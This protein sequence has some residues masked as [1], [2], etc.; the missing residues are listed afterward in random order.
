MP[1][2]LGILLVAFGAFLAAV[3][4]V[5]L[6]V[7]SFLAANGLLALISHRVHLDTS[8]SSVMLL[9]G[10]AV[11]VDYCMFYLR[12]VARGARAGAR[13]RTRRS[14]SRRRP[15][16]ARCLVSGLTVVV[17]MSG[18]FLSGML[19][20]DGFAIAA[21]LV[22]L[23]AVVG[24]VTVLPALLS[25][26][27]DRVDFGRVPGLARMRRPQRRQQGVGCDPRPRPA[28]VQGCPSGRPWRSCS[29][30]RRRVLGIT[31]RLSLDKLLPSSASIMQSLPAD[32][33]MPSRRT[34]PGRPRHQGAGRHKRRHNRRRGRL[35]SRAIATQPRAPADPGDRARVV[36]RDRDLR[37]PGRQRHRRDVRRAL[38]AL[39]QD[40][41]PAPSGSSRARG[42]RDR[43]L[44]F[45]QDFNA[46]L[47]R[48]IVPVILFVLVIAFV[49]MLVAFRSVTIA[50]VSVLL[51]VLS[52]SGR[53]RCDGGC[54]PARLGCE[55]RGRD[56]RR[57]RSSRGSRC[58]PS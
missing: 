38:D 16:D 55:P 46:Q 33:V 6:A 54:L 3:L 57:S 22:V 20:F 30:S 14:A 12:R 15:Q 10:L 24:S 41:V 42:V 32:H 27:G 47:Q 17:A 39:R 11:G 19:L 52:M 51:N 25:V 21:I 44:A 48:S 49:L 31:E 56:R 18:M 2:A 9:V 26:L 35:P 53:L 58:S 28:C 5:G 29:C 4:P 37:T 36:R 13:I 40:V 1:L 8:T 34:H 50:A 23:V 45:S 43:K 7:T